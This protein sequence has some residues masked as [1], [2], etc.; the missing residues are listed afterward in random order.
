MTR[1]VLTI[2]ADES[3]E[4]A[5]ARMAEAGV[6]HLVVRGKRGAVVG[7]I[8]RTDVARAPL[9][10]RVADFMPHRLLSVRSD[11]PVAHAAALMRTYGIGSL[12]V[13]TGSRLIGIVT[14]SD[15]LD[16]V[17]TENPAT[18]ATRH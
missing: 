10:A 13:M 16:L 14:V 17:E 12:P 8:S 18:S 4:N 15:M 11:T 2:A 3:I 7:V 6:H 5:A 1:N 9:T